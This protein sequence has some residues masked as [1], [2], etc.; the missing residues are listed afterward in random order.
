VLGVENKFGTGL[1]LPNFRPNN[2]LRVLGEYLIQKSNEL[3][4]DATRTE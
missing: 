3:E 2:P 1:S 4:Q